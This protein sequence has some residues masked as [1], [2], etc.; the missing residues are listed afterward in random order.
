MKRDLC[1]K[2]QKVVLFVVCLLFPTEKHQY[3]ILYFCQKKKHVFKSALVHLRQVK[4]YTK[5]RQ[6]VEDI[7]NLLSYHLLCHIQRIFAWSRKGISVGLLNFHYLKQVD[8]VFFQP[9]YYK[10]I[11]M[12]KAHLLELALHTAPGTLLYCQE[13]LSGQIDQGLQ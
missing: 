5:S 1:K 10:P 3:H 8:H 7:F 13:N 11:A 12:G 4:S 6:W 2:N 9:W